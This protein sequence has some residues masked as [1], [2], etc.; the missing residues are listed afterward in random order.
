ML[1]GFYLVRLD[2]LKKLLQYIN[3]EKN[4][5]KLRRDFKNLKRKN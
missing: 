3:K 1:A 5:K 2:L 4:E